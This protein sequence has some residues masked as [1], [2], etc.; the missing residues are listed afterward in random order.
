[1][2]SVEAT[3]CFRIGVLMGEGLTIEQA[4]EKI[5]KDLLDKGDLRLAKMMREFQNRVHP[6]RPEDKSL[7]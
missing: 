6:L 5:Y 3:Y 4:R 7:P 2:K 1:M